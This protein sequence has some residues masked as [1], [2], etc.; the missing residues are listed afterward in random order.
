[1]R[2]SFGAHQIIDVRVQVKNEN[3]DKDPCRMR[4]FRTSVPNH[5]DFYYGPTRNLN[6]TLAEVYSGDKLL[7][8]KD[9]VTKEG[10]PYA[11][12]IYE[13]A[14]GR[15]SYAK[16]VL[17]ENKGILMGWGRQLRENDSGKSHDEVFPRFFDSLRIEKK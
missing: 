11:F 8:R 15:I 12:V 6:A 2:Q 5:P 16:L 7:S 17:T 13:T 1:M 3:R 4:G 10:H 14:L 9:G